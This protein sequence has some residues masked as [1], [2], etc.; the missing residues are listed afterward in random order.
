MRITI[1]TL[2]LS[3]LTFILPAQKSV[4]ILKINDWTSVSLISGGKAVAAI[5]STFPDVIDTGMINESP[6]HSPGVDGF[7]WI[8]KFSAPGKVFKD[9]S[10]AS[11]LTGYIVTELGSVYKTVNGGNSWVSKMNLGYPYYWYGVDAIS[12]DTVIISGFNNQG[13]INEGVV[14]WSFDGGST[15]TTDITLPIPVSGVGWLDKV[16]FFNPDT[17]IVFNSFSGGCWY[18]FNGG[19]D[20]SSWTYVTIDPEFGWFAGNIDAEKDGRVYTAGIHFSVG[21]DFGTLW[22]S[23]PSADQ[24]FDGGVDILDSDSL[25]GWTGGGQIS[26]PVAGWIHRTT[27]GGQLWSQRLE[28]FPYPIRAVYFLTASTGI[29]IGGNLY[30]EAGGI[31]S[32]SDSGFSWNLDKNTAAEM[33]A[34]DYQVISPDSMDFWCVGST[35]GGTGFIG[36]LFKARTGNLVT[37]IREQGSTGSQQPSLG[38]AIPNPVRNYADITYFIPETCTTSLK[39]YNLFGKEITTLVDGLQ[40]AGVHT[41]RFEPRGM[42]DGFYYYQLRAGQYTGT[43]KLVVYND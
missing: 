22:N 21:T 30:D 29:A 8:L 41:I 6:S 3:L 4:S 16:H 35:G 1:I 40:G 7:D 19:K 13:V 17:G 14:R 18:T 31:Y 2:I 5:P 25:L 38:L 28:T 9:V 12:A 36:R 27:D 24:V 32:T 15:W 10:F 11:P 26:A 23:Y 34:L 42:A 20:S 39:V 37:G 33:F 43:K